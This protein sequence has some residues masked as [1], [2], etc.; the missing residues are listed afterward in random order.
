MYYVDNFK[1]LFGHTADMKREA[2]CPDHW[3]LLEEKK[4]V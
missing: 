3:K 2:H 1:I 4:K